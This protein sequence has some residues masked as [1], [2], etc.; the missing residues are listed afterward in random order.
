M[1]FDL[2]LKITKLIGIIFFYPVIHVPQAPESSADVQ[3]LLPIE[4]NIVSPSGGEAM[5]TFLQDSLLALSE[6]VSTLTTFFTREEAQNHFAN[7]LLASEAGGSED[8]LTLTHFPE[9]TVWKY[10]GWEVLAGGKRVKNPVWTGS[11]LVAALL[12]DGF[13]YESPGDGLA[14]TGGE[15]VEIDREGRITLSESRPVRGSAWLQP[16][17]RGLVAALDQR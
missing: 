10:P 2:A 6:M 4:D 8:G 5:V 1:K 3:T 13:E 17:P 16:G 11:Q 9:P 15:F 14:V 12:P 7:V